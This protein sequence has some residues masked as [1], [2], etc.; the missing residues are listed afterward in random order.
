MTRKVWIVALVVAVAAG[1]AYVLTHRA[2]SPVDAAGG[3]PP[4][5]P[6][7]APGGGRGGR[8][9]PPPTVGVAPVTVADMP[10]YLDGLGTIQAYNTVTVHTRV[11][12]QLMKVA[13]TE[14]QFVKAGDL[15]A[16]LDDRLYQAAYDQA[17]AKLAQDQATLDNARVDLERYRALASEKFGTQQQYDT[18]KSTVAQDEATVKY[19]KAAVATARTNLDYCTITAPIDGRIGLRQVDVGNIAHASDSSGLVVI[20]QLNPISVV[21]TL[22]QQNL[23]AINGPLNR[24]EALPT[25]AVS[26]D[27]RVLDHG[28][29]TT[30]DNQIDTSTGTLKLKAAFPNK[31][32]TLWPGGFVNVRLLADTRRHITVVPLTAIQHGPKGT[33]VYVVKDDSTVDPRPVTVAFSEGQQTALT[34]GVA[35]GERVVINGQDRLQAGARIQIAGVAPADAAPDAAAAP[36]ADGQ[37]KRRHKDKGGAVPAGAG[38]NT[39]SPQ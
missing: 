37:Q 25:L 14:G 34:D 21:F 26:T 6:G 3:P 19:D 30:V 27:G 8:S 17:V 11:D 20:T 31:D 2:K 15:L 22:P 7:G 29:L 5:G 9:G 36:A 10:V 35:V 38:R 18:Q 16:K 13:F 28:T 23:A 39:G 4:G 32:L 33:Y 24:G 12:G 1:G